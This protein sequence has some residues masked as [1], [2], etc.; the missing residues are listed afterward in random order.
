MPSSTFTPIITITTTTTTTI[1]YSSPGPR[2][3]WGFRLHMMHQLS[4]RQAVGGV[5]DAICALA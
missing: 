4:P 3:L 2:E 5:P 1:T